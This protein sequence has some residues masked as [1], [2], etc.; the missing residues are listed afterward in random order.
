MLIAVAI[1]GILASIAV[2]G[3]VNMKKQAMSVEAKNSLGNLRNM[4]EAYRFEYF[5]YA[6]DLDNVGFEQPPGGRYSYSIAAADSASCTLNAEGKPGTPVEDQVWVLEIINDV[7][8][9]PFLD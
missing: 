8:S 5:I 3:F 4:V 2:G 9:Q 6:E 7:A 1:V